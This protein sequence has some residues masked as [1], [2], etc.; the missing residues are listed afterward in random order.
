MPWKLRVL[1]NE[2]DSKAGYCIFKGLG[3][4]VCERGVNLPAYVVGKV[5]MSMDLGVLLSVDRMP[6][7][8]VRSYCT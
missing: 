7:I 8:C 4:C 3:V 2:P 6:G 1:P 5:C